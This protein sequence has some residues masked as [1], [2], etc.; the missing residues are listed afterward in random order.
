MGGPVSHSRWPYSS[1]VIV[2]DSNSA[3]PPSSG[4]GGVSI[5]ATSIDE[6]VFGMDDLDDGT[7]EGA[8][9]ADNYI[10]EQVKNGT[11]K[12]S[13]LDKGNNRVA[14]QL[15]NSPTTQKGM[16]PAN[17]SAIHNY[18]DLSTLIG[19]GVTLGNFIKDY[20]AIVGCK[21]R[22]VPAQKGLQPDQIVCNLSLL[23]INAWEPIKKQ[24]P[25]IVMTN[26]LRT[27]EKIGGGCHGTGQAMDIQFSKSGGGSIPPKDYFEIAQWVKNNIAY[28][29]LL[30]EY[31]TAK[32][33]LVAW[34][35]ISVYNGTGI[36]V[37]PV[38]RVLT[39]MNDK[40]ANVG[41]AN[42]G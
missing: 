6:K 40:V 26:S 18:F 12:Q 37:N 32:G 42:L 27:G 35:H 25:N 23:C 36:K 10:N 31:S 30:L 19:T 8:Q 41:L 15:D 33:Y 14:S 20:P 13:D 21:Q 29:Q 7:P 34:L 9:R 39:F 1:T 24:Y 16:V 2:G 5:P 17:C 28:D 4:A 11:F 38:N 22:F 3:A